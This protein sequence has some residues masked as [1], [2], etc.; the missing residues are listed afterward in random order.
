[1]DT[2]VP[3][4]RPA[5][6]AAPALALALTVAL[7]ACTAPGDADTGTPAAG[8]GAGGEGLPAS[9]TVLD[10]NGLTGPVSF[11]GLSAQKGTDL[12]VQD[13][14]AAGLLGETTIEVDY[15]DSAA[16]PQE[17]ASFVSQAISDPEVVAVLGP[18]AS[19]Q[20]TAVSPI[21]Q[22]AGMPTIYVQSGSEGV[23]TGDYTYRATPPAASY[24]D[25]AGEYVER[26]G[27]TTASVLFNNGNPTLVQLGEDTV[28]ALADDHGFEIVGSAGVEVTQQDFTTPAAQIAGDDPDAAFLMLQGPQYPTAITQLRQAGFDGEIVLMS[29]AGAGNLASAGDGAEG[30]VWPTNFTIDQPEESTQAFVTAYQ[31]AYDGEVPNGYAAEAYDRMWFLARGIAEADSTDRAAIQRGLSTIAD[32]GFTGAQGE[33]TFQDNDARVPG[34]LVRWDG[35][36]E[37]PVTEGA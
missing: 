13:I 29:A 21:V 10:V 27:V 33:L 9:I 1:M 20:A 26:Q 7:G 2:A 4:R 31:E 34:V 14:E 6:I 11:A 37:V 22:Q 25:I 17:A 16:S 3:R 12:A 30:V 15:R 24:F 23:I 35:S 18:S 8:E 19:S 28:P 36:G 32:E 5:L